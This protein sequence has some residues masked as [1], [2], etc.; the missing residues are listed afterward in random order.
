MRVAVALALLAASVVLMGDG[1]VTNA[2][3]VPGGFGPMSRAGGPGVPLLGTPG[4]TPPPPTCSNK[5]DFSQA[6]NSQYIGAF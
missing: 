2:P 6:C 5:M 3:M 4:T 1:A